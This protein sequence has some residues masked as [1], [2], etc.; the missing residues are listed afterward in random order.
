[1]TMQNQGDASYA[2]G[3]SAEE[4]LRL[5]EQDRNFG[6]LTSEFFAQAGIQSGMRVLDVG[7]GVGD[8]SFRA[9]TL[10]GAR[11]SVV[12]IDTDSAALEKARQRAYDAGLSNVEFVESDLREFE[13]DEPFDAVV[14]RFIL[15]YVGDPV[16]VVH[17][18]SSLVRGGGIV[19]FHELVL[20]DMPSHF[21]DLP[22]VRQSFGWIFDT[23]RRAGVGLDVGLRLDQ[24]F[25]DAG[26]PSPTVRAAMLVM[27]GPESP[28]Y[29]YLANTVRSVLPMMER[30]GVATAGEVVIETLAERLRREVVTARGMVLCPPMVGAWSR[31]PVP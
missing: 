23:F 22:L 10:A 30:L 16:A 24:I 2:L 25:Q 19:T 14:G 3:H 13:G 7:C 9:A 20:A 29:D 15:V 12:G 6:P 4:R 26:L 8:V 21:P 1:M 5:T 27:T 18:L 17:R 28:L 11:G 31:I